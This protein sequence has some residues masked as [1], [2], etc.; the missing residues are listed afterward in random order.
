MHT[1]FSVMNAVNVILT[2]L[3]AGTAVRL[4]AYHLTA[5]DNEQVSHLGKALAFQY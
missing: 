4:V 3:I 1:H 2:V 5:S